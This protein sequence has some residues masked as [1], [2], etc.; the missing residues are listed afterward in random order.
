LP[1]QST[2]LESLAITIEANKGEL[3]KQEI[4][5]NAL[6]VLVNQICAIA[7]EYKEIEAR[8]VKSIVTSAAPYVHMPDTLFESVLSFAAAQHL[9]NVVEGKIRTGARTRDYFYKNI[10]VIPDFKILG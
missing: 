8:K 3:E 6:D 10:S 7:L 4:E 2:R 9:V 1:T 5:T